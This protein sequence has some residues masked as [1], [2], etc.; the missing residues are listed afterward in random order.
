MDEAGRGALAGPVV[1]AAVAF[2]SKAEAVSIDGLNDSKRIDAEERERIY[3]ALSD[4]GADIAVARVE[5]REIDRMNI[6]QAA[7][8][9]M[10]RAAMRLAAPPDALLVDGNRSPAPRFPHNPPHIETVVKGDALSL[11]IAA[12]SVAAKVE[13]DRMMVRLDAQYPQYGFA[14]HKGYP[15][16]AHREAIALHGPS[17][18][19]RRAFKGVREHLSDADS[20]E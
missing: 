10:A 1:A 6:L 5:A 20:N 2:S 7:L 9:A 4:S 8:E 13:R 12:A 18:I 11:S 19:H 3:A 15:T 17:P 14:R 16:R